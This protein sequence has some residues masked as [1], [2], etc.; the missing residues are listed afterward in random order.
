MVI[1]LCIIAPYLYVKARKEF[2]MLSKKFNR[3]LRTTTG[4]L[5]TT[6]L[7]FTGTC[8]Y[9]APTSEE[10]EQKTSD[11]QNEINDI[12]DE[13]KSLSSKLD[14]TSAQ[15]EEKTAELEKAE[16]DLAAAKLNEEN[17]YD[18]MKDRI[19]FMYEGGN[20]SLLQILLS[21]ESMSDFLNNAEYVTTISDYD[22][23]MLAE[24]KEV[25]QNVEKKQE[26]LE[27][28]QQELSSLEK[29]LNLQQE[30]L[31]DKLSS[32]SK[33]L[34]D[35]TKQLE[36]AKAAEEAARRAKESET[37]DSSGNV[38]PADV[39]TVALMAG[40]LE[41]EAGI[42]YDGM[43]AVGTVIMNRVASSKF[44]NSIEGVVYQSGQFSPVQSGKLNEV[45]KRGPSSSAYSAAKAVLG[46]E[47]NDKVKNCL[48]FWASYTGRKGIIVGDNVFW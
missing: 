15:I 27:Q 42:S 33:Q 5:C 25:C 35:Y 4:I 34:T 11:L 10:L 30:D 32:T 45:L 9:A 13:L 44:P 7:I 6:A 41:C 39:S 16:L 3:I 43:I 26:A 20:V 37:S 38:V 23:D 21:S 47:R 28:Q 46:G 31:N 40:I 18:A 12:N 36:R 1:V 8:A 24:F 14:N 2:S 22:R 29:T 19:K 17:Q 48:Y